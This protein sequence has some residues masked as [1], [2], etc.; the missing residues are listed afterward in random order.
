MPYKDPERERE[1]QARRRRTSAY[2]TYQQNYQSQWSKEHRESRR[3]IDQRYRTSA[4]GRVSIAAKKR[5]YYD[6]AAFAILWFKA[7][8]PCFDCGEADPIVLEFDHVRGTKT[9]TIG[10]SAGRQ[11]TSLRTILTEIQKCDVVCANCHKWR[12]TNR[13]N[14]GLVRQVLSLDNI[15]PVV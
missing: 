15:L 6:R 11:K 1:R 12:T 9:F 8:H 4:K 7:A 14:N 13:H 10:E 3:V 2:R 5:R